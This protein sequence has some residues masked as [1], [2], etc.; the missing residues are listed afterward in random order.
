MRKERARIDFRARD[1]PPEVRCFHLNHDRRVEAVNA[2]IDSPEAAAVTQPLGLCTQSTG[3]PNPDV[4]KVLWDRC[5]PVKSCEDAL[6]VDRCPFDL[7]RWLDNPSLG[8][9]LFIVW[10]LAIEP[11]QRVGPGEEVL[12]CLVKARE[13]A[14]HDAAILR[15]PRRA[16]RLALW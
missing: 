1:E 8:N 2:P 10:E 14:A 3:A 15:P 9:E 6:E 5:E 16:P 4:Q 13:E 7:P 11:F 12:P